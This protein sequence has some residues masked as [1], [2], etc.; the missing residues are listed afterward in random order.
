M[1]TTQTVNH[2]EDRKKI[3]LILAFFA[4]AS[5]M[6][7]ITQNFLETTFNHSAFYFSEAFMFSSFWWLFL[8]LLY[9]Q[10]QLTGHNNS[11]KIRVRFLLII[12][13]V[14]IHLF[15]F[16]LLV[17][18]I[19]AIFYYHTFEYQQTLYYTLSEYLYILIGLYAP[20]PLIGHFLKEKTILAP[21]TEIRT[22]IKR[23]HSFEHSLMVSEGK[24]LISLAVIRIQYFTANTP[25]I[26]IHVANKKY[27]HN[28][29]LKSIAEKLDDQQFV[30]VHK[31]TII[32]LA[33]VQS[34]TSRLNGDYDVQMTD[35]R[36]LRVSRNYAGDFKMKYQASHPLRVK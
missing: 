20:L 29:T 19:S 31:S 18:L 35:G 8:P 21:Q 23:E 26:N 11:F 33:C 17:R 34:Y 22:D 24:T 30:R 3:I 15:A 32:N 2:R 12:G 36:Q 7:S 4:L 14:I 9:V 28:E 10:Y 27:L 25:Y 13:P 1:N 6:V 16:P 5:V